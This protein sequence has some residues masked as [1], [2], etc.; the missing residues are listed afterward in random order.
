[1]QEFESHYAYT[2]SKPGEGGYLGHNA[3]WPLYWSIMYSSIIFFLMLRS[4]QVLGW[5]RNRKYTSVYKK[6]SDENNFV[7]PKTLHS[8]ESLNS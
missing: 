1:M 4:L 3:F 6:M 2:Q 5:R 8:L 7:S